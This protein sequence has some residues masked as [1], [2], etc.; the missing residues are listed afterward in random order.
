MN[1][2]KCLLVRLMIHVAAVRSQ[3]LLARYTANEALFK[4]LL[5]ER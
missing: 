4:R 5:A 2:T 1:A 3:Y